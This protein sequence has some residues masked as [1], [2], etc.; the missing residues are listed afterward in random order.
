MQTPQNMYPF[1]QEE[2]LNLTYDLILGSF[3]AFHYYFWVYFKKS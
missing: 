3:S 1:Y 2:V